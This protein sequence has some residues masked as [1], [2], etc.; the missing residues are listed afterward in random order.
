MDSVPKKIRKEKTQKK[1]GD[2]IK[3]ENNTCIGCENGYLNQL[4]HTDYGGC[5]YDSELEY[6]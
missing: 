3:E 4:G 1:G 2:D 6:S 5:L